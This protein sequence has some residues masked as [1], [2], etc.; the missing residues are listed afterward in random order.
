MKAYF[1]FECTDFP[2][3]WRQ[4]FE[5][6]WS[7]S[8]LSAA[9]DL[10]FGLLLM[11]L[12]EGASCSRSC[13]IPIFYGKLLSEWPI[14]SRF[15]SSLASVTA[16]NWALPPVRS[17]CSYRAGC[18]FMF[19]PCSSSWFCK[20]RWLLNYYVLSMRF[21]ELLFFSYVYSLKLDWSPN[22]IKP[23]FSY[24]LCVRSKLD[25]AKN[26]FDWS[27][28]GYLKFAYVKFGWLSLRSDSVCI[29]A[30]LLMI[31]AAEYL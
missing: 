16:L 22:K 28:F 14:G 13:W 15:G 4:Y 7:R 29:L 5:A 27:S 20:G 21:A 3:S 8:S 26:I 30:S 9:K 19:L 25:L 6:V 24:F 12:L 23:S 18:K 31:F 17:S 11:D 1:A 2:L 10:D